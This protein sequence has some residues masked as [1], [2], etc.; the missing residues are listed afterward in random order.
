M[1]EEITLPD[2][3]HIAG[4]LTYCTVILPLALDRLYTYAVPEEWVSKLTIGMRVEV[5]FGKKKRYAA[6]VFSINSLKPEGHTPKFLLSLID[7][8]PL[9]NV[10]QI[11]FWTWMSTYY[12]CSLGEIM[13]AALPSNLK[14]SSESLIILLPDLPFDPLSLP[15]KEYLIVEALSGREYLHLQDI[16]DM[17]GIKT[18][19]PVIR[20]L[21]EKGFIE[22]KEDLKDPYKPPF[23]F[24]VHLLEPFL[25]D[26]MVLS[27][28]FEKLSKFP[29]QEQL[30]L[31][32]FLLSKEKGRVTRKELLKRAGAEG[33]VLV[34][35]VKKNIFALEETFLNKIV[36]N[37]HGEP[38]NEIILT[39]KQEE[40]FISIK[41]Y[42]AENKVVLL[43]G[44]TGSGKTQIY[45]KFM[46]E[47]IYQGGQVLYLLPEIALSNQVTS[48]L[49]AVFHDKVLVYHSRLSDKQR[50]ES[51]QQVKDGKSL[52][53]G[54]RS[55]LFLPFSN[56]KLIIVDEEHDPSYKQNE[57][58][59][60]YQG[61]DSAVFLAHIWKSPI[62]LGTATP[63]LETYYH[64]KTG[65]Y[66]W[67]KLDERYGGT[68]LPKVNVINLVDQKKE[69]KMIQEFSEPLLEAIKERLVNKEQV[70]LFQNRRG[71]APTLRCTT[72]GWHSEC[73]H[74]DVSLTYH[75]SR[76]G[77][78]CHY[79]G[80]FTPAPTQ[81]PA[82]GSKDIFLQGFGTEKIEAELQVILPEATIARM[83][84]DT[85]K[86]KFA[87]NRLIQSFEEGEIDIL[88]GT[89]MVT[90]GLD[91]AN[92][93][94][95]GILSADQLMQYPDFRAGERAFQLMTQVSG[96]AGR[97][98]RQGQVF[99]QSMNISSPVL[100]DI[101]ENETERYYEREL[102]EREQFKY[103]PFK[104]LIR[105]SLKHVDADTVNQAAN[106]LKEYLFP[107]FGDR[108]K[109]P[110]VPYIGRVRNNY[111]ID[112]LLKL[113]NGNSKLQEA[114]VMLLGAQQLLK[115]NKLFSS[116]RF[117]IDVDP[118]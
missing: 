63:S 59:P 23:I 36:G 6:I 66:G 73:I 25:S 67:V 5:Q 49:Q 108:L 95:V 85:V 21:I 76:Q 55:S 94:M 12:C 3:L 83:D 99:I 77:L 4:S 88:I 87:H 10:F 35:L 48:R 89:Q 70:I 86:S 34:A 96:R 54:A 20:E 18:I 118:S 106:S 26:K 71:F 92:V 78:K 64:S 109:G 97:R 61:R 31:T 33:S 2:S 113:D 46:R 101:L 82:C 91:F 79:C 72:C 7:E 80:Y 68:I 69:K 32:Y 62:I 39:P 104:R 103:P 60:R 114:K 90:K 75:K 41:N 38:E 24:L 13:Q 50:V 110:A 16:Q 74:C 27:K 51:W 29:K 47:V 22:I 84:M 100:I 40:A 19:Y 105:I 65:K 8:K 1:K 42:H 107:I 45:M 93:G 52:L 43:Q 15:D 37:D 98:A 53:V 44:I 117:I 11:Q 14:L 28:L 112:F 58:N 102:S 116:V 111:L 30:L 81:C 9:V 56:L 17:L 57:P 115:N